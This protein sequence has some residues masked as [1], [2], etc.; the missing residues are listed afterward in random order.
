MSNYVKQ[1]V[2]FFKQ[3]D[4]LKAKEYYLLASNAYGTELF[5]INIAL[6]DKYLDNPAPK[7]PIGLNTVKADSSNVHADALAKQLAATQAKLEHYYT[8]CQELQYQLMD[9]KN[10]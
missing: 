7:N 10:V 3:G 9:A 8:R 1:A 5:S 4:Y 2:S 6:C